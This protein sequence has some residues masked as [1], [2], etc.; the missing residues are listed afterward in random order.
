MTDY[1]VSCIFEKAYKY[2]INND[3]IFIYNSNTGAYQHYRDIELADLVK[4]VVPEEV[5]SQISLPNVTAKLHKRLTTQSEYVIKEIPRYEDRVLCKNGLVMIKNRDLIPTDKISQLKKDHIITSVLDFNYIKNPKKESMS[6]WMEFMAFATGN[7]KEL[8]TLIECMVGNILTG[9]CFA[10]AVYILGFAPRSG[11]STLINLLEKVIGPENIGGLEFVRFGDSFSLSSI[12]NKK[13]NVCADVDPKMTSKAVSMIKR[14][15][16]DD[17][18][19]IE[20]KGKTAYA[21]HLN[22][23][24]IFSTN[25]PIDFAQVDGGLHRRIVAIPFDYS[26]DDTSADPQLLE[27]LTREKDYIMS[28]CINKYRKALIATHLPICDRSERAKQEWVDM[29]GKQ[30]LEISVMRFVNEMLDITGDD[31]DAISSQNLHKS[32]VK[33]CEKEKLDALCLNIFCREIKGKHGVH[34]KKRHCKTSGT[35][36]HFGVGVRFKNI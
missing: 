34:D 14:M 17:T 21:M 18:V 20:E 5:F 30:N 16:G 26:V 27:F 7:D 24:L 9:R 25:A 11:K 23:P 4:R 12:V 15:S 10:S 19:A 8:Q 1:D 28:R 33:F 22:I 13:C 36:I 29:S 3:M 2:K 6:V 31:T 35:K 32:Y